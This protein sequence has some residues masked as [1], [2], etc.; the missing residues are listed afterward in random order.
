[1]AALRR[2]ELAPEPVPSSLRDLA[3]RNNKHVIYKNLPAY[4]RVEYLVPN[5]HRHLVKNFRD[6]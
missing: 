3:T 2:V 1:L 5:H 4:F 6:I